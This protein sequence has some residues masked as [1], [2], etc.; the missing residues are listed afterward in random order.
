MFQTSG[1]FREEFGRRRVSKSMSPKKIINSFDG[2]MPSKNTVGY[3][4][5]RHIPNQSSGRHW[6]EKN[7][8][9]DQHGNRNGEK[10]RSSSVGFSSAAV[11]ANKLAMEVGLTNLLGIGNENMLEGSVPTRKMASPSKQGG[12]VDSS[13]Q[14]SNSPTNYAGPKFSDAPPPAVLP[15]PPLH[16]LSFSKSE[17]GL[18]NVKFPS[19]STYNSAGHNSIVSNY[20]F[21]AKSPK[22]ISSQM[23]LKTVTA[24]A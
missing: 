4:C 2:G 14:R 5:K 19:D 8:A 24:Q 15:P 1:M 11:A 20:G 6:N 16:W 12:L 17:V 18:A 10:L 13:N 9:A 23:L 3:D 7:V 21:N 22:L